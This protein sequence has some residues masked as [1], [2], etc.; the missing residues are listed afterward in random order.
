MIRL[1]LYLIPRLMLCA[2]L[3]GLFWAFWVMTPA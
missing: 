2:V 3:L 1:S